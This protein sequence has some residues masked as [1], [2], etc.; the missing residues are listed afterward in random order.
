VRLHNLSFCDIVHCK[1]GLVGKGMGVSPMSALVSLSCASVLDQFLLV[2]C[3]VHR[4]ATRL[5]AHTVHLS[6]VQ[7]FIVTVHSY[8]FQTFLHLFMHK[9][10]KSEVQSEEQL[11]INLSTASDPFSTSSFY[12]YRKNSDPHICSTKEDNPRNFEVIDCLYHCDPLNT[13]QDKLYVI[14]HSDQTGRLSKA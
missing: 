7:L 12:C 1:N 14:I 6:V 9:M 4:H 5:V 8:P 3:T 2:A 10:L 11:L 13:T